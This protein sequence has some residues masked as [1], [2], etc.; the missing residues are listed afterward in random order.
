[1]RNYMQRETRQDTNETPL[2]TH[3]HK[4]INESE[5]NNANHLGKGMPKWEGRLDNQ[6]NFLFIQHHVWIRVIFFFFY[7]FRIK[8]CIKFYMVEVC[9]FVLIKRRILIGVHLHFMVLAY[10]L[11]IFLGEC[12]VVQLSFNSG[13]WYPQFLIKTP[14]SMND[15]VYFLKLN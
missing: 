6:A 11:F 4:A 5:E 9:C 1:M 13:N 7:H 8:K 14:L 2:S 3:S 10:P 12:F 15:N